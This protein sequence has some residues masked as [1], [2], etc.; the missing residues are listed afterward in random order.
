MSQNKEA[1]NH[2]IISRHSSI[3]DARSALSGIRASFEENGRAYAE[4]VGHRGKRLARSSV[5][6]P[7]TVVSYSDRLGSGEFF[8]IVEDGESFVLVGSW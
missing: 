7:G 3:T 4:E 2:R 6:E 5:N 1:M 8:A